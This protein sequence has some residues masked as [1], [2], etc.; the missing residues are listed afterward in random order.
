MAS[1][2]KLWSPAGEGNNS[3]VEVNCLAFSPDGAVLASGDGNGVI[4]LWDADTGRPRPPLRQENEVHGLTFS[5]D[6]RRLATAGRD[7][8]VRLWD[9]AE[10]V[11][12]RT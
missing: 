7:N 4:R 3:R 1:G 12:L 9:W 5:R 2:K 10:G 11:E 6:G 8:S